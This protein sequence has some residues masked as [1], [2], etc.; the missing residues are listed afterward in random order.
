MSQASSRFPENTL[1]SFE[2]AIRDGAEGIE[3]GKY[4]RKSQTFESRNHRQQTST[5]PRMTLWSCSTIRVSI[6]LCGLMN[7]KL[8]ECRQPWDGPRIPQVITF[9]GSRRLISRGIETRPSTGQIKERNWFGKDGMQHVRTRKEP[10]Q[11]IPTFAETVEL[12]M[13]ASSGL[14]IFGRG[15][16]VF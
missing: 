13:K 16:R 6:S 10:K 11:P 14:L 2:A 3:S 7:V 1:A 9:F 4:A 5:Y 15:G 8:T 12:L